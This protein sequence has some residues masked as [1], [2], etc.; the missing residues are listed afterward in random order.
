MFRWKYLQHEN[1]LS[2]DFVCTKIKGP[3]HP[4]ICFVSPWVG[5]VNI[6]TFAKS[7]PTFNRFKLASYHTYHAM[8][9]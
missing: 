5:N 1:I 2:L 7:N 6:V 8:L 9:Y 4:S 3:E